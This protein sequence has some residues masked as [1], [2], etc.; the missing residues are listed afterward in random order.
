MDLIVDGGV[1]FGGTFNGNPLALAAA[2]ATIDAL[3][4]RQGA[5]LARANRPGEEL[6]SGLRESAQTLGMPLTVCG[7]GAAFAV[8]FSER[9]PLLAY[10]DTLKDDRERLRTF[11]LHMLEEGVYALP[12]GRFYVSTAHSEDDI[13]ETKRVVHRALRDVLEESRPVKSGR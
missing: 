6:M 1:V 2:R 4:A 10:R 5:P 9:Q 12:D 13:E 3:S 11:L 8:H 7:F